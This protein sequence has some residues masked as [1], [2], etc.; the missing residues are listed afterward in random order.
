MVT[1]QHFQRNT[2]Y[3]HLIKQRIK[4][5]RQ[6]KYLDFVR[7]GGNLIVINSDNK[8]DG[9]F[10][11]LLSIKLGNLTK[12]NSIETYHSGESAEKKSYYKHF[13]HN[14]KPRN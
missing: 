14:E 11:K 10:S 8:F 7:K 9:I 6:C 13:W 4:K 3:F 2:L 5:T 1:C 12:F